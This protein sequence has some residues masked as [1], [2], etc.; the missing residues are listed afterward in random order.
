[1]SEPRVDP[2]HPHPSPNQVPAPP[3]RRP[4]DERAALAAS[5]RTATQVAVLSLIVAAV[6]LGLAVWQLVAPSGPSCQN[7]AWSAEPAANE[8]PDQWTVAGTT[9]DV[10]RRTTQFT[11]V[12]PGDG[13]GAPNVLGTVTCFP[14]GAADAV[15]RAAAAAKDVGQVVEDRTDLSDGGFEATDASGAIFLEFRRGDIVVDLA[16]S[17]GATPT[18]IETVASAYDKSLGGDG[19]TIATPNPAASDGGLGSPSASDDTGAAASPAAPELEKLL[20]TTVGSVTLTVDSA[21]GT[22]VLQDDQGSRA[23]TAALRAEGKGPEALR[24][25]EAYDANQTSDL[26]MLAVTVEGMDVKKV[27]QLVLDSWLAASGAGVTQTQTTLAGKPY[28]KVDL[29]DGGPIDYVRTDNGI[30]FV[31]TTADA[32]LAEQAAAQLP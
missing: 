19:G 27:E 5:T 17:G 13:S 25:A 20:P 26:N 2:R 23:I 9:F 4:S 1:M 8:L 30:V 16:A 18:D 11:G 10:N 15:A 31:I 32:K 7:T 12:D 29:G 28:T 6:A 24:L 14:D 21:L 22:D 3:R